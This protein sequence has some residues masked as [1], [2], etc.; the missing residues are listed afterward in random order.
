M[1]G[2]CSPAAVEESGRRACSVGFVRGC[3]RLGAIFQT[4]LS[5]PLGNLTHGP[6]FLHVLFFRREG[7]D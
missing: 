3:R 2:P 1:A 7:G 5:F 4:A 6:A